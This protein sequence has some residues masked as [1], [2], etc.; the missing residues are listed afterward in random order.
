MGKA[1]RK[2]ID[3]EVKAMIISLLRGGEL[4][5]AEI[6]EKCEVSE[7]SVNNVKKEWLNCGDSQ[8]IQESGVALSRYSI[9][10]DQ[11]VRTATVYIYV[12]EWNCIS[13]IG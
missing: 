11:K 3:D 13:R 2:R 5:N 12:V 10:C 6:A 4:T 7:R 8:A 1:G 9:S